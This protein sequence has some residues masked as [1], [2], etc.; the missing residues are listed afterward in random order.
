[1]EEILRLLLEQLS[2]E[3]ND[4]IYAVYK[5]GDLNCGHVIIMQP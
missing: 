4:R 1:M 3:N 2:P 5:Y